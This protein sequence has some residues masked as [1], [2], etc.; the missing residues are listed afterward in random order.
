MV[1]KRI[2]RQR[3]RKSQCLFF[4]PSW[5]AWVVLGILAWGLSGCGYGGGKGGGEKVVS[6]K[7]AG[8]SLEQTKRDFEAYLNREIADILRYSPGYTA[9]VK[10]L[11]L[12]PSQRHKGWAIAEWDTVLAYK[13]EVFDTLHY[14]AELPD[15]G[16]G[17][18]SWFNS[19][20]MPRWR[21]SLETRVVNHWKRRTGSK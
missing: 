11:S 10:N 17:R 19:T 8:A 5:V 21:Q 6:E 15:I 20:E 12:G 1:H 14:T 3:L 9:T 2:V 16:E 13:G 4:P 7:L 18:L